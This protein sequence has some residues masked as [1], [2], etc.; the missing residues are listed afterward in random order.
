MSYGVATLLGL[1]VAAPWLFPVTTLGAALG[2]FAAG[3]IVFA[4]R[5]LGARHLLLMGTVTH[6]IGFYWLVGT[7]RDFGGFPALAALTVLLLFAVTAAT[8]FVVAGWV[9]KR[10][11]S[12]G[13]VTKLAL[14]APL[15]WCAVQAVFPQLFPW[16]LGHTQSGFL[17]FAQTAA[18]GGVVVITFLMLWIVTALSERRRFALVPVAL[19]LITSAAGVASAKLLTLEGEISVTLVQANV[20]TVEKREVRFFADNFERYRTLSTDLFATTDLIVW[21]ES[22][23]QRWV[24]VDTPDTS[25]HPDLASLPRSRAGL[26][27]GALTARSREEAYNSAL[28]IQPDGSLLAPYHKRI[29]M[30]FG[31]FTPLGDTLPWLRTLNA[32]AGDFQRGTAP[33]F[34]PLRLGERS[35]TVSPLICY[36]DI[37]PT[38]SRE[39]AAGGAHLLVSLSNDAWFGDTAA[40]W[41]HHQIALFRS[42]ETGRALVRATNTGLSAIVLPTGETART[43]P[44]FADGV[45][46]HVVPL[47]SGRSLASTLGAFPSYLFVALSAA[48]LV[49]N[50]RR[51]RG[52]ERPHANPTAL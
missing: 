3:A 5:H 47:I 34:F 6:L 18:L 36:E 17:P 11:S 2:W 31:E 26:I 14:A 35:V 44:L 43:L 50:G 46:T 48:I 37:V 42:I 30:P 9:T 40:P 8:Q 4:L 15:G 28:G 52:S 23:V 19:A 12:S 22:V 41:Q 20:T 27:T 51:R 16:D 33:G 24:H 21:P 49:L 45:A 32:S 1:I 39:S 10:L 13:S 25:Y 29:L 38:L 7:V